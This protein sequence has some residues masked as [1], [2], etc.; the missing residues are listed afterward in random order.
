MILFCF[1]PR[2]STFPCSGSA[3][4]AACLLVS[5]PHIMHWTW[6]SR[7]AIWSKGGWEGGDEAR[8]QA[9]GRF[10]ARRGGG[11]GG[12]QPRRRGLPARLSTRP[13]CLAVAGG[14]GVER[15]GASAGLSAPC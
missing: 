7:G 12:L 10:P 14:W 4:I 3:Q 6:V 9:A 15:A 13:T 1:P 8:R 5:C 2:A 11:G